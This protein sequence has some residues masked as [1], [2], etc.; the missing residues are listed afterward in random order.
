[1]GTERIPEPR[2]QT[3]KEGEGAGFSW[4]Y[5][6]FLFSCCIAMYFF[7]QSREKEDIQKHILLQYTAIKHT[8]VYR[9]AWASVQPSYQPSNLS[10][11]YFFLIITQNINLCV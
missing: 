5:K 4:P 3:Q 6:A 8:V 7:S 2:R 9:K 10:S 1:L 11:V